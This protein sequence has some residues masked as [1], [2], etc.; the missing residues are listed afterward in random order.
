MGHIRTSAEMR[1]LRGNVAVK[2][3]FGILNVT[4][5]GRWSDG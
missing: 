3:Y 4:I 2:D 1:L 5:T